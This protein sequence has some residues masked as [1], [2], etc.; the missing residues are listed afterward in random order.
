MLVPL[1]TRGLKFIIGFAFV[2]VLMIALGNSIIGV[3]T[4]KQEE[5]AEK[6]LHKHP[7]KVGFSFDGPLGKFDT[8]QLQRGLLVYKEVCATCHSASLVSFREFQQLGY[9]EAQA[10]KIASEWP[11]KTPTF[12][13]KTGDRAERDNLLSDRLPHVYYAAN[14]T[15]PDLSL[16]AKARHGGA[17]Y[18]HALL[19]GYRAQTAEEVKRFPGAKTPDGMYY[20]PYF[21]N[22]N[23]SMP[24]PLTEGRVTYSDGTKATVDQQAKD[25][26][27]F[28]AWAAEP[29]A[30]SRKSAGIAVVGFLLLLSL[31]SYGAYLTVWRGV[32]H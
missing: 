6:V 2:G 17:D 12:D 28:L 10:K 8:A 30:Q 22:L 19:T 21:A 27:A 3:M 7:H 31:L 29:T 14:G 32:K 16:I 15:P 18:I 9:N 26:A 11:Q 1:L 24:P 4:E 13:P 20:N 25:V 5:S 23:I